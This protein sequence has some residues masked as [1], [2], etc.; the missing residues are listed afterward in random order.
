M[1]ACSPWR[2]IFLTSIQL[3]QLSDHFEKNIA[4][5]GPVPDRKS[6]VQGVDSFMNTY[7]F[8][9]KITKTPENVERVRKAV[10][11]VISRY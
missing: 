2:R 7:N 11:S 5:K 8:H 6:I 10:L 4:L 9:S 3:L 1:S